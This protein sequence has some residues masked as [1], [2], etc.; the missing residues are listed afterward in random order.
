MRPFVIAIDEFE[1]RKYRL[2]LVEVN[3]H[4]SLQRFRSGVYKITA[5]NLP[6]SAFGISFRF[7][8]DALSNTSRVI[9]EVGQELARLSLEVLRRYA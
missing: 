4:A 7:I 8:L 2:F 5:Y 1:L 6:E 3:G 9:A